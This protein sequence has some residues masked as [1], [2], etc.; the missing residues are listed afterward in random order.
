[1]DLSNSCYLKIEIVLLFI[2]SG[3]NTQCIT[4]HTLHE[5]G[6]HASHTVMADQLCKDTQTH[7]HTYTPN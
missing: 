4:I 2:E 6:A 1:M 7:T 5:S 3:Q